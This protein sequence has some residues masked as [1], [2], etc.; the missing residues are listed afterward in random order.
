MENNLKKEYMRAQSLQLCPTL[1]NPINCSLPDSSVHGILQA[2]IVEEIVMPSFRGSSWPRDQT[3]VSHAPALAGG[4]FTTS[5][6][7]EAHK[8]KLAPQ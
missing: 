2:R 7:W 3:H 5:T 4:F 8:R 6:T 1:C